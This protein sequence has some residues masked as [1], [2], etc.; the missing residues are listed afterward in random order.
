MKFKSFKKKRKPGYFESFFTVLFLVGLIVWF[1]F[2]F[3]NIANSN[4]EEQLSETRETIRK[5]VVLCYSIEGQFPPNIE[6]LEKNYNLYI[7][8]E[9]YIV[10]YNI[11]ASN[12]M[13]EIA[14]F[15]RTTE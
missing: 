6:Y 3:N 10:S 4:I 7:N 2:G 5:C 9:K 12:I 1:S 11:F 14:V 8:D 13:P 15:E